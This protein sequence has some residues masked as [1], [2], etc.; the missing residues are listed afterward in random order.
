MNTLFFYSPECHAD[1]VTGF[2]ACPESPL[3]CVFTCLVFS[4]L[5]GPA[6]SHPRLLWPFRPL[7][8]AASRENRV[9]WLFSLPLLPNLSFSTPPLKPIPFSLCP[10]SQFRLEFISTETV[11]INSQQVILTSVVPSPIYSVLCFQLFLQ[12]TDLTIS[13]THPLLR[14][15]PFY[16]NKHGLHVF[17]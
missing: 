4:Q 7:R 16:T 17:P 14:G 10:L 5:K 8:D 11:R 2:S 1:I 3:C 12:D 15:P 6:T 9:L 13:H